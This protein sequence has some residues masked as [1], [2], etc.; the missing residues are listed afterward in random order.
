VR[1]KP[2]PAEDDKK[3]GKDRKPFVD[4]VLEKAV[5]HLKKEIDKGGAAELP[6]RGNA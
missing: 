2:K 5:E 6:P 4:R 3:D 1:T